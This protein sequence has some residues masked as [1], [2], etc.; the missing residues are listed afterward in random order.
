MAPD[1]QHEWLESTKS[2]RRQFLRAAGLVGL[3]TLAGCDGS[4]G[5][6]GGDG[7]GDGGDGDGG[8]DDT[9]TEAGDPIDSAFTTSVGTVP[10]DIQYNNYNATGES[11][12]EVEAV[13]YE[14]LVKNDKVNN[15]WI[16]VTISDWN[17]DGDTLDL[18]LSDEY[19]WHDGDSVTAED[20]AT[21]FRIDL[22]LEQPTADYVSSVE[23]TGD[24]NLRLTLES[25]SIN[26]DVLFLNVLDTR[27]FTK[28]DL[29]APYLESLE[30]AETDD[31]MEAAQNEL[32]EWAIEEPVG[33]GPF[34]FESADTQ[35][36]LA[37]KHEDYPGADDINF[38]EYEFRFMSGNQERWQAMLEDVTDGEPQLGITEEVLDQ[39]PDHVDLIR[40]PEADGVS[41]VFQHEDSVF[42]D[43]RVRKA[44]TYALEGELLTGDSTL[45]YQ[46][47][48][49]AMNTGMMP[50][51]AEAYLSDDLRSSL[52]NYN[53]DQ[54]EAE[55]RA[56][57]LLEDAGFSLD[58]DTWMTPEGE[59]FN[60]PVKTI[61][62]W[63]SIQAQSITAQLQEFGIQ[64]EFVSQDLGTFFE[65]MGDGNYEMAISFYAGDHP[66]QTFSTVFDV[67]E[68]EGMNA[69]AEVEVPMPVGDPSGSPEAV[70]VRDLVDQLGNT[71]DEDEIQDIVEELAWTYNQ[72]IPRVP[73]L[74]GTGMTFMTN[75]EWDYPDPEESVM[76]IFDPPFWLLR[77]G[78]LRAKTE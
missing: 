12:A 45:N 71:R 35:R 74:I 8:D 37:A 77:T 3:T 61:G 19:V 32:L 64:A 1:S 25:D 53:V 70:N 52:T 51:Q 47:E 43:P 48:E 29:Y 34:K 59:V 73:H 39:M 11:S 5:G 9:P 14:P 75:D 65:D 54:S 22:A 13:V 26:T 36:V 66:S 17:I 23:V 42:S 63:W 58:G 4:D 76:Q 21:Q 18:E 44:V 60:V 16:P 7:A 10:T 50:T 68:G 55:E 27:L 67:D 24:H 28:A 40:P 69:P 33:S 2:H 46:F 38:S 56:T 49:L 62:N 78:E 20:L 72:S 57:N 41:L 30:K 31:E 15:E 6:D